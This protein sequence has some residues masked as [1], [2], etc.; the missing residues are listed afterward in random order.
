V[1]HYA[2][3]SGT[4]GLVGGWRTVDPNPSQM[5][6]VTLAK[7]EI[8]LE[9]PL[10]H[11]TATL[12]FSGAQIHS[13]VNGAPAKGT[14][15][16]QFVDAHSFRLANLQEGVVIGRASFSLSSDGS[17]ITERFWLDQHPEEV[18]QYTYR[19]SH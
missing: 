16:L 11:Q 17:M 14:E 8:T 13:I 19:R 5:L 3:L 6:K 18:A 9:Y 7:Q 10:A 12:P 1:R 4:D 2:R 15:T